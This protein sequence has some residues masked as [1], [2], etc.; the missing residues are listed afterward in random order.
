MQFSLY[1]S[2]VYVILAV[3]KITNFMDIFFFFN[4]VSL[5]YL[6]NML[7]AKF[8]LDIKIRITAGSF[9]HLS[10]F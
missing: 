5:A 1:V 8:L 6:T 3:L 9:L 10:Y 2:L 4:A 7:P